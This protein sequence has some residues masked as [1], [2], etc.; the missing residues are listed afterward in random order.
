MLHPLRMGGASLKEATAE[1]P[2]SSAKVTGRPGEG[3]VRP[4]G[5][6]LFFGGSRLPHSYTIVLHNYRPY[7]QKK[8]LNVGSRMPEGVCAWLL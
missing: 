5:Q 2:Q 7:P 1:G 6:A 8:G 4:K 3:G